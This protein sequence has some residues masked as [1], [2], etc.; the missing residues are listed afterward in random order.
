[1]IPVTTL[2]A[3]QI[4]LGIPKVPW[5]DH[6]AAETY[7]PFFSF[8][9]CWHLVTFLACRW[10]KPYQAGWF[11]NSARLNFNPTIDS[12]NNCGLRKASI[13]SWLANTQFT[14]DNYL[15]HGSGYHQVIL[16][17]SKTCDNTKITDKTFLDLNQANSV[18]FTKGSPRTLTDM[19]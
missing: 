2:K 3:K 15:D 8:S 13:S 16:G 14:P 6:R 9:S 12:Q 5:F 7:I 17:Q 4:A 10:P 19:N 11:F 18:G 1:M